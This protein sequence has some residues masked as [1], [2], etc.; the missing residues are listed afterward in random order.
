MQ[1]LEEL[2]TTVNEHNKL[3]EMSENGELN[4]NDIILSRQRIRLENKIAKWR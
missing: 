3:L 4:M 2:R 1:M